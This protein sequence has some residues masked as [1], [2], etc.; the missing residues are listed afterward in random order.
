MIDYQNKKDF[1]K[2]KYSL[3]HLILADI[4]YKIT[5]NTKINNFLIIV[6]NDLT[7]NTVNNLI[8]IIFTM[9]HDSYDN[10][11][12]KFIKNIKVNYFLIKQS[13]NILQVRSF[14]SYYLNDFTNEK[15]N[16]KRDFD[17]VLTLIPLTNISVPYLSSLKIINKRPRSML[18]INI[19]TNKD[20]V[21]VSYN[22]MFDEFKNF[23]ID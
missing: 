4:G 17:V 1:Y 21:F 19:I 9:K 16:I 2:N 11:I 12:N 5:Q 22:S 8:P 10:F 13:E 23:N 3:T 20:D 14:I 15:K 7:G 18:Y 6:A